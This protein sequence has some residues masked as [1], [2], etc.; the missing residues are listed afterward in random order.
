M[1]D[2][3]L[4][5]PVE[6][7]AMVVNS[8]VAA[9]DTFRWWQFNYMAL[10]NFKSPE[11]LA[12]DRS[13]GG[14]GQGVHLHWTLPRS[15]RNGVQNPQTGD[16]VYPLVPNR[17]LIL[18]FGGTTKRQATA[19]WVLES[20]CPKSPK[21]PDVPTERTSMYLLD[22]SIINAWL[23]SPD[24]YRNK[25]A[26]NPA[27]NQPQ[28]ANLGIPF[29][30]SKGWRERD[31]KSM[32]LTALA[33]ANHVFSVYYP[34]NLGVFSFYDDLAGVDS[35]TLS[36]LVVGWY[37]DP[38]RDVMAAWRQ[39]TKS[40]KPY[41]TL[42]ANLGWTV[43]G[44]SEAQATA[45]LYEGLVFSIPWNRAG[46]P[47]QD[48][49]LQAIRDS[50]IL[51]VALGNTG[52]DSFTALV[53]EQFQAKG[54][55]PQKAK[56]LQAFQYGL[57]PVLNQPNGQALLDEEIRA[58][59]HSSKPGG[60][61]WSIVPADSTDTD[62]AALTAD[63]A[64]W[65][66][67]LNKDQAAL[68]AAVETL[69]GLQWELN[70]TW[71]R[72]NYLT[73]KTNVFPQPPS[74]VPFDKS[75]K[76][77]NASTDTIFKNYL[78][79]L[80]MQLDPSK[81]LDPNQAAGPTNFD[82]LARRVV[83]QIAAVKGLMAKV[84][85]PLATASGNAQDAF[86]AGVGAFAKLK[87]LDDK[88]VLKA[89]A[90]PRYWRTNN[91]VVTISGV[92]PPSETD[93]SRSLNVRLALNLITGF[94][95][96]NSIMVDQNSAASA[97][98][99]MPSLTGL[100]EIIPAL[101]REYFFLDPAGAASIAA[102][103]NQPV[104][105]VSDAMTAHSA[106]AYTPGTLPDLPLTNW[107]QPWAPLFMEWR[108]SYTYIADQ[109]GGRPNWT[110][111]GTDYHF[112]P[113]GATPATDQ[114]RDVGGISLLSPQAKFVFGARLKKF[115]EQFG[116]DAELKNLYDWIAE[117]DKWQFL[118]QELVGFNDLLSLRDQRAFRRPSPADLTP[119]GQYPLA[120]LIGYSSGAPGGPL[121]L[122]DPYQG[123]VNSIPFIPNGPKIPFHGARQG[124][125]YFQDLY[126]YDKFGRVLY[127]VLSGKSTGLYDMKNFP[128]VRDPHLDPDVKLSTQINSVA[129]LPPRLLQHSRLDF[130]LVDGFQDS[131]LYGLDAGVNPVCGW[132]LP[133]HLDR[134]FLIYAPDGRSMGE[135]RL[136]V[137][138]QGLKSGEWQP[139]PHSD[140]NTLDDV[141]KVSPHLR[142]MLDSPK[143]KDPASFQTFLDVIDSTLWTTDALGN[144]ADEN[145]SVLIGRPLA[146]V[147]ARLQF[148]LDGPA[149]RDT[150]WD[151]SL[152]P[153]APDFLD[154]SFAVRLGD[155]ATR[156]DGVVGYFL[157]ADYDT[158]N[159]VSAPGDGA[160]QA[161]VKQIGPLGTTDPAANYISLKCAPGSNAFVTLL[162]DPRAAV[163][164]T[165]G[166]IPV[167]EVNLPQSLV[168]DPLSNIEVGFRVGPLLTAVRET[169]AQAGQ[170]PA[171][172]N[173]VSY[174][175]PAEQ[176][177]QWSWWEPTTAAAGWN[178]Y[179]LLDTTPNAKLRTVPNTLR[180]GILQ[181]VLDL[182]KES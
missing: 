35:D 131:K 164:A 64:A 88:K 37:S 114:P 36:Y 85:Q 97:R 30:L 135:F 126:L 77:F 171:Y 178:G 159:S 96:P 52:A 90:A 27:L 92:E 125:I 84:P 106:E 180:E 82:S 46:N 51:N 158:F 26:F 18:R 7:D 28:V 71:Y 47:P 81:Q 155:Q 83:N 170:T 65:L 111:D 166:L 8:G 73:V 121:S 120:D 112:T 80:G 115:V 3:Y 60:Y 99:A 157:G 20:D 168:E 148:A 137:N 34:H 93:P 48:D 169:P 117:I 136:V 41:D 4:V 69:Y 104:G 78:S 70:A 24:E 128:V 22:P 133:N 109:T 49:P 149:I 138:E 113:R 14:P 142:Q 16:I 74:G 140:V 118:S 108:V 173:A 29:P 19:G 45:S 151:V 123:Q 39:D 86:L 165:T 177:G 87:Q 154:T 179:A 12:L 59:W 156:E 167:K 75:K 174:P 43:T 9:R 144:R 67:Q 17:W 79:A 163:H 176:N 150:G 54:R 95:L 129:Q 15:L 102:A 160:Q 152:N 1:P 38:T 13:A 55:D 134:S 66:L 5:V 32:F 31:A 146:L 42:L 127:V 130:D 91:P 63:E 98:P 100:P 139:P 101:V 110:F 162:L 25:V 141:G 58:A 40:K 124:Q 44:G 153:P 10:S 62:S 132:V 116:T 147:R 119:T 172:P 11:P 6:L 61:A 2:T 21:T 56:L 122:P 175:A 23:K 76:P 143:L 53:A 145:L 107:K 50:G 57:L 105:V 33:P 182:N 161:Y 72:L 94:K 68:D 89:V 181:L 103:I